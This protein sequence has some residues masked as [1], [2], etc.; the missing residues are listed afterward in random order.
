MKSPLPKYSFLFMMILF[1]TFLYFQS[2]SLYSQSFSSPFSAPDSTPYES[3]SQQNNSRTYSPST[4]SPSLSTSQPSATSTSYTSTNPTFNIQNTHSPTSENV[5]ITPHAC[6]L[7]KNQCILEG[8][9][10]QQE[11][12]YHILFTQGSMTLPQ[13]QIE[14]IAKDILEIYRY[15]RQKISPLDIS[16][17]QTLIEWCLKHEL[18]DEATAE[19]Q[20]LEQENVSSPLLEILKLRCHTLQKTLLEQSVEE[21]IFSPQDISAHVPE[22]NPRE[23]RGP[24]NTELQKMANSLP[25]D[26]SK[27]FAKKIQPILL[28]NCLTTECHGPNTPTEFQLLRPG[29]GSRVTLRNMHAAL[30]QINLQNPEASPLLRKPVTRHG[31]DG[32]VVFLS[33]DYPTYQLLI[34]WT[35]LVAKNEYVIPRDRLLPPSKSIPMLTPTPTGLQPIT[36]NYSQNDNSTIS[37]MKGVHPDLYPQNLYPSE[38]H[39]YS[40]DYAET[41][42][43]IYLPGTS[44][45]GTYTSKE[46]PDAARDISPAIPTGDLPSPPTYTDH[47]VTPAAHTKPVSTEIPDAAEVFHTNPQRSKTSSHDGIPHTEKETVSTE[48]SQNLTKE[49]GT[50]IEKNTDTEI[51]DATIRTMMIQ[52]GEHIQFIRPPKT[53]TPG[54]ST[55]NIISTNSDMTILSPPMPT[56]TPQTSTEMMAPQKEG[57]ISHI[58]ST[59]NYSPEYLKTLEETSAK[60]AATKKNRSVNPAAAK[61]NPNAFHPWKAQLE[62]QRILKGETNQK[63]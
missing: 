23:N 42:P 61:N 32:H 4:F 44:A 22:E 35:Y 16:G 19:I 63:P 41:A 38:F 21:N 47:Q 57:I 29:R 25:P 27:I 13:D 36:T 46:I 51:D 56:M 53:Y 31:Q 39:L 7:L 3:P 54:Q 26:V 20:A 6:V 43:A 1:G 24:S 58:D 50:E 62:M 55:S 11:K 30:R 34:A 17:R 9:V 14:F 12:N 52:N 48:Y 49:T 5:P 40:A 8:K 10:I 28:K 60:R 33:P 45:Q 37:L 2:V 15:L 59:A 18:I